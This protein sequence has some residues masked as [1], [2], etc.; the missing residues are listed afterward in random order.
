V[1]KV[2][3]FGTAGN[4]ALANRK[5][6]IWDPT[7]GLVIA[8]ADLPDTLPA[9]WNSFDLAAPLDRLAGQRFLVSYSTGGRY[10][11]VANA[12]S[13]NVL[14]GDG[15]ITILSHDNSTGGNGRINISP[16]VYPAQNTPRVFWGVDIEYSLGVGGNTRPVIDTLT[17]TSSDLVATATITAH[18]AES[19]AGATVAFDWG[20]GTITTGTSLTGVHTYGSAGVKSVMVSISDSGGL[21]AYKAKGFE[22]IYDPT[23]YEVSIETIQIADTWLYA[24]LSSDDIL[25]GMVGGSDSISGTLSANKMVPPYVTFILQSSR[26]VMAV[27]GIRISTDNLYEVK[28]VAETSSWGDLVNIARRI[29]YLINRPNAV[30]ESGGGSLTC[31]REQIIQYPEVE[32]GVQY[33]H[34]GG[35]YRIRASADD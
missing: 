28:A 3:V 12:L 4:L 24:T 19:L 29:D 13:S 31:V 17:V 25:L 1:S 8:Q 21:A 15:A 33:R 27:G 32:S 10:G 2:R 9:G 20:D 5:A 30:M 11:Y 16:G 34:L 26:D 18:D 6:R 14:S 23:P 35:I 7:S 22:I